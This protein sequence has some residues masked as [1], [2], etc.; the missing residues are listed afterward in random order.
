MLGALPE[1]IEVRRDQAVHEWYNILTL[2]TKYPLSN[3]HDIFGAISSIAQQA[4][5]V[6]KSH[7]L[8]GLWEYDIARSL[9]W[10]PC[11]HF[12]IAQSSKIPVARPKATNI[13]GGAGTVVRALLWSWAAVEGPVAQEAFTPPMIARYKPPQYIKVRPKHVNPERWTLYDRCGVGTSHRPSWELQLTGHVAQAAV[14]QEP[15]SALSRI[16]TEVDEA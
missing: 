9:L 4:S 12:Q 3:S 16:E 7:Y 14:S 1:E 10:R 13:T 6:L 5:H 8:A 2:F 15:V 11:Y